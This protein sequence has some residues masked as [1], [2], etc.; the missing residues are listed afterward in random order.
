MISNAEFRRRRA[1]KHKKGVKNPRRRD[2]T[3]R[4][5]SRNRE[6][7]VFLR[8]K[9][10]LIYNGLQ[11]GRMRMSSGE[12]RSRIRKLLRSSD[13]RAVRDG[14]QR[15]RRGQSRDWT[16][17]VLPALFHRSEVIGSLAFEI[18]RA[19]PF[20]HFERRRL[21]ESG[22]AGP[23]P[24]TTDLASL[25]SPRRRAALSKIVRAVPDEAFAATMTRLADLPGAENLDLGAVFSE[26][27]RPLRKRFAARREEF[28][29]SKYVAQIA[30]IPTYGCNLRCSYCFAQGLSRSFPK[31]M[32]L[33]AYRRI[34]DLYED[35]RS[36]G[37]VNFLG[38]EPT[39]FPALR[40]FIKE[41]ERRGM[42]YYFATNGLAAAS[43]FR[44]LIERDSL[45][46]VTLHVEQ[47][48]FY[49]AAQRARLEANVRACGERNIFTVLRINILA[50]WHGEWSFLLPYLDLLPRSAVSFAVP[51]PAQSGRNDHVAIGD[52]RR[53][54]GDAL[55]LV[56]FLRAR[57]ESL[58]L[59][60]SWAKPFPPCFFSPNELQEILEKSVYKN[61]CEVDQ[62]DG[63]QN[64]CFNP[65]STS[66]PCMALTSD[67]YRSPRPG[68]LEDLR[69]AHRARAERLVTTPVMP[70]CASCLLHR[71]GVCQAA[72]YAYV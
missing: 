36:I 3:P 31:P 45:I 59:P 30:V 11:Q 25:F 35:S 48:D 8:P 68:S 20:F 52:L 12:E 38:G 71:S 69:R 61:V 7:F 34:L 49:T 66:F 37:T 4:R 23:W 18:L 6:M 27:K 22:A 44:P 24:E 16:G 40:D 39:L 72:C 26:A 51:F 67:P 54:A 70:A 62:R 53:Y 56:R 21:P 60:I 42:R 29:R 32:T 57:G 17:D 65:D 10:A 55:S 63:M 2:G 33:P 50:S 1:E 58:A 14:L 19:D 28:L 43:V 9:S 13:E 47:D 64:I 41:T 5:V 15:I 46:N